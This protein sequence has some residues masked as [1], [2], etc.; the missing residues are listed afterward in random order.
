MLRMI[1]PLNMDDVK[2]S[3]NGIKPRIAR[4][5]TGC[6]TA[7]K[8]DPG[9]ILSYINIFILVFKNQLGD[10]IRENRELVTILLMLF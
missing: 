8:L 6:E 7:A 2:E 4:A 1:A 9:F 3:M 10:F 5:V